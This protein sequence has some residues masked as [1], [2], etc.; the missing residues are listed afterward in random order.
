MFIK[1]N[2]ATMQR[3]E[4]R[5]GRTAE[6]EVSGGGHRLRRGGRGGGRAGC[7]GRCT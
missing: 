7:R 6:E 1:F 3:V 4:Q 2:K 5:A